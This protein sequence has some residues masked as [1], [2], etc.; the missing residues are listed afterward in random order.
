MECFA[1]G[2]CEKQM[3]DT[4]SSTTE[5]LSDWPKF[6]H[7]YLVSGIP[8]RIVVRAAPRV[9][10][11]VDQ[12]A[13]EF[14]ARFAASDQ[15]DDR[16][17]VLLREIHLDEIVI[18]GERFVQLSTDR[19]ALYPSF[20]S[21]IGEISHDVI[22]NSAKPADAVTAAVRRWDTLLLRQ[23]VLSE[24]RQTGLYGEI[25]LL[26]R[27]IA[28]MGANALSTW[29]GPANQAHDFRIDEKEFEVK[30]TSGAERIHRINGAGQLVPS[31][32]C[33][34]YLLSLQ[35]ANAGSGGESLPEAVDAVFA[36]LA[37]FPGAADRFQRLL[38]KTGYDANDRAAYISRRRLRDKALLIPVVDGVPRLTSE[39]INGL[40]DRYSPQRISHVVYDINVSGLGHVDGTTEFLQIIPAT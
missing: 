24:E 35:V 10:L 25:W 23:S 40:D 26:R 38:D 14:G 15:F 8:H 32:G 34:L 39:A 18:A 17:K 30:T 37:S 5:L 31:L 27:L 33:S 13:A 4:Q 11:F 29:V 16:L 1:D 6:E 3:T 21:L 9:E 19:W 22:H 2:H 12:A 7:D 28:D 20:F 36:S